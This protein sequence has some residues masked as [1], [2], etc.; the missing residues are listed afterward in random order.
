MMIERIDSQ[1][2]ILWDYHHMNHPLREA[3]CLFVLCS[4]DLRVAD[5]AA[6]LF[7]EG[8]A[9]VLIFSGGMAHQNDLLDTGWELSE[10]ETFARRALDAGVPEEAVILETRASNTGENVLFTSALLEKSRLSF[11]T[12][13]AVQKPYM[14]RRAWAAIRKLR[15]DWDVLMTSPPVSYEDYPDPAQGISREDLINIM[16]GDLQRIRE[17]P[18]KGFQI[19]QEIPPRVLEAGQELIRAGYDR[20]LIG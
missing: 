20:H 4:H 2:R 16:V 9:P 13:L 14:E 18:E 5:Y 11:R 12:F 7:L 6:R 15:P 8:W 3:D 10:A 17:Y 1:A 19:P